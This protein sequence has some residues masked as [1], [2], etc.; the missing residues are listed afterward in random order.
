MNKVFANVPAQAR[1]LFQH[2]LENA[3][4]GNHVKAIEQLKSAI[5]QAPRFALAYNELAVQ[6]L[7]IGRAAQAVETLKEALGIN[8]ED[9]TLR[10]NYGIA[11]LNQK[12]FD[13]AETE[14]RLAIQKS[15]ADSSAAVTISVWL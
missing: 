13:A 4:A 14:L 11:L 8:P 9:F 3:R 12:K 5:S 7:R 1:D 2:A 10:L 15:N 6:Y